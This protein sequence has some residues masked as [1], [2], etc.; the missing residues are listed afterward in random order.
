[1]KVHKSKR[2]NFFQWTS[3][4]VIIWRQTNQITL[5]LKMVGRCKQTKLRKEAK[6]PLSLCTTDLL[7]N[8]F[9]TDNELKDELCGTLPIFILLRSGLNQILKITGLQGFED[10]RKNANVSYCALLITVHRISR[11][12]TWKSKQYRKHYFTSQST[13]KST[14]KGRSLVLMS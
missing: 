11:K 5:F 7:S 14:S 9:K 12:I 4:F 1:M 6:T 3:D 8:I 10:N 13:L 2:K